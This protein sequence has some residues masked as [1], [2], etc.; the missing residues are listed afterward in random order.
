MLREAEK[1]A[2]QE[3]A[4]VTVTS[5]KPFW[6][7]CTLLRVLFIN[8]EVKAEG[9]FQTAAVAAL[10]ENKRLAFSQAGEL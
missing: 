2:V 1:D 8:V 9:P 6:F 5:Y 7:N 10:T 4:A 3:L